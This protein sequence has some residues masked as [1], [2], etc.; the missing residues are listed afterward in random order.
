MRA[1]IWMI[2]LLPI[3]PAGFFLSMTFLYI[4]VF[5]PLVRKIAPTVATDYSSWK[6]EYSL[7]MGSKITITLSLR[8]LSKFVPSAIL[9]ALGLVTYLWGAV[10]FLRILK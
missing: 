8:T 4:P 6:K 9:I 2:T 3:V 10:T 5:E 1:L 7:S